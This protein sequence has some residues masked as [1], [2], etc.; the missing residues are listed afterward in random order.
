MHCWVCP[1]Y[2]LHQLKT[3]RSLFKRKWLLMNNT[4]TRW[5]RLMK[6]L[7][8]KLMKKLKIQTTRTPLLMESPFKSMMINQ[9]LKLLPLQLPLHQQ[10][11]PTL[12]LMLKRLRRRKT[13][14]ER[15]LKDKSQ[16]RERRS[17]KVIASALPRPQ[18]DLK[19]LRLLLPWPKTLRKLK[20]L[21][22]RPKLTE[23]RLRRQS[24]K[25]PLLSNN[26]RLKLL[27]SSRRHKRLLPRL[28]E[29]KLKLSEKRKLQVLRL[30]LLRDPSLSQRS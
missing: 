12:K 29:P 6:R 20:K 27:P 24:S 16:A 4:M 21:E 3:L 23:R 30:L 22:L 13:Q 2:R 9:Q 8:K 14:R 10:L 18:I 11:F 25:H 7:M 5:H 26:L 28:L 19:R 15:V 17:I 1:P